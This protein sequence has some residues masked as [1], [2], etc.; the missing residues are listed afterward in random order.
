MKFTLQVI[1]TFVSH[2]REFLYRPRGFDN[3]WQMNAQI[4]E[5]WNSVVQPNDDVY[6]LGDLMLNNDEE[7]IRL[8]KNLKGNIHIIRGN[9]DSNARIQKYS[10]CYNVVEI[11]EGKFLNYNNYLFYLSHYPS[12]TSNFDEDKPLKKRMISLCGHSHC[13]NKF[14]DMNKGLIFHTEMDT[15]NCCPWLIDDIIEEIKNYIKEK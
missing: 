13:K 8:I 6:V 14:Q 12:L 15:N 5:N 2:D 9:H 1:F 10:E 4:I 7:G 3:V 11:C